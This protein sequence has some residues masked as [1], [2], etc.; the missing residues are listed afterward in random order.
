M[1]ETVR[2]EKIKGEYI[3]I[4]VRTPGEYR[5]STIPGAINIALFTDEEREEIGRVYKTESIEKAKKIGIYAG[6]K[7][8][9]K[10]YEEIIKLNKEHKDLIFF[11][12]KG[13]FRSTVL[14]S[15]LAPLG[16]HVKKL[17]GGYKEY[18]KYIIADLDRLIENIEAVVLYGNTGTG[19]TKILKDLKE[20][21]M[22]VLDLEG[23]ANHR[24]SILGS[25]GLGEQY[26]QKKFES[27]L[28]EDL[29]EGEG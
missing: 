20:M 10:I 24:G 8:L 1:Y 27:L 6:S 2:Y 21:G 13:G 19:K 11:C 9:P 28:Y 18:R 16:F 12:A 22:D 29:C 7:N 3:L 4:D 26:S 5:E 25:V 17:D 14:V 23:Y 15:L